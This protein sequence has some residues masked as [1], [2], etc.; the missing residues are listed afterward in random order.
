MSRA[1]PESRTQGAE[2][3]HIQ[4]SDLHTECHGQHRNW[5]GDG[6]EQLIAAWGWDGVSGQ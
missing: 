1:L 5:D 3:E 4:D 2:R 6:W